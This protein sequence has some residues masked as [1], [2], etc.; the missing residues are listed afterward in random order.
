MAEERMVRFKYVSMILP[1]LLLGACVV[2]RPGGYGYGQPAAAVSVNPE[3]A[4]GYAD[5]Y[6]DR[7]HQ[8]HAWRDQREA[9]AWQAQNPRHYYDR[10]HDQDQNAGWHDNDRWWDRR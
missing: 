5:G 9:Q 10:R 3:I 1:L 2:E 6:W 4:F 7:N 8:W